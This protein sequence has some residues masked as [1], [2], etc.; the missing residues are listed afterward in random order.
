M[1][2]KRKLL[3]LHIGKDLY[4]L[5]ECKGDYV[6]AYQVFIGKQLERTFTDLFKCSRYL[7]DKWEEVNK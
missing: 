3:D 4:T 5:F 2:V 1:L 6:F 7:L